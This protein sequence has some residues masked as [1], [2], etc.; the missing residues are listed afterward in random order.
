M[1][2][3]NFVKMLECALKKAHLLLDRNKYNLK[4]LQMIEE[5]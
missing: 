3:E 2:Q 1:N 5:N 4:F